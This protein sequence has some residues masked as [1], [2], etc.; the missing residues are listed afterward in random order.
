MKLKILSVGKV[1][2]KN[3]AKICQE[4]T[5]RINHDAQIENI[6]IKDQNPQKEG[7]KILKHLKSN[8]GFNIAMSEEGEITTSR[9]LALLLKSRS[10]KITFII[11]GPDG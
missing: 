6:L 1:K 10:E 4:F 9:G 8:N 11:G 7:L 2:D 5:K 3:I